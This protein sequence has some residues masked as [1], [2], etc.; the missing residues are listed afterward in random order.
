MPLPSLGPAGLWHGPSEQGCL[1]L[2]GMF[3][4]LSHGNVLLMPWKPF[5]APHSGVVGVELCPI[6]YLVASAPP[7]MLTGFMM[8]YIM[9]SSGIDF[10]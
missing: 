10:C 7:T 9:P 6:V 4:G 5:G 3:D 8:A 2:Q 1:W